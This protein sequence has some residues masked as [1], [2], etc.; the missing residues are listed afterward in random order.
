M[1]TLFVGWDSNMLEVALI[2][3]AA[4][5]IL[6]V[7]LIAICDYSFNKRVEKETRVLTGELDET[8]N[9]T[10]TN[11]D[12][13]RLPEPVQRYFKYAVKE[14]QNHVKFAR[15]KHSGL[16]RTSV[17]QKWFPIE[18]EEYFTTDDPAFIWYAKLKMNPLVWV[19][20]RDL[21]LNGKGNMFIKLLSTITIADAKGKEI[22]QGALVRWLSETPWF[23]IALL[24]SEKVK[25][26]PIDNNSAKVILTDKNLTVEG[27]FYFNEVGQMIQFKAKRYMDK[28]VENWNC[29]YSDYRTVENMQIPFFAE[30]V[31]NLESGDF[32]YAKFKIN[33]IEYLKS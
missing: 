24:P 12:L 22:D 9:E 32:S 21:Y 29:Y 10:F 2:G 28:T 18:G 4:L 27:T 25:W 5:I 16:F 1:W 3:I 8:R 17:G 19:K 7:M 13:E 20:A 11:S 33:T 26:E 23:P 14:R 6:F 15:L 31:W 30:A